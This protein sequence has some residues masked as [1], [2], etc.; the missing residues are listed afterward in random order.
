MTRLLPISCLMACTVLCSPADGQVEQSSGD[1]FSLLREWMS[2]SFSSELQSQSDSDFFHIL[3]RMEPVQHWNTDP[4]VYYLYVE[5]AVAS[6]ASKPYRQRIY[7]VVQENPD[8]F[9]SYI[10]Q[11][12]SPGRFVGLNGS[13][14]LFGRITPDSL[15]LKQGCEVSLHFDRSRRIFSGQTGNRTCPSERQGASWATS[16]VVLS[17]EEMISWDR[18]WNAEGKQVW[19]AVKGGYRFVRR[20]PQ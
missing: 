10:Y 3:L 20:N 8:D 7:R 13:D 17:H 15:E 6:S 18:G 5:Q 4:S 16:E 12:P 14:P 2:G 9:T 11:L 1:P 19:G